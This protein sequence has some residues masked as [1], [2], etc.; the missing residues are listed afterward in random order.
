MRFAYLSIFVCF[1]VVSLAQSITIS[2]K[3]HKTVKIGD[4]TWLGENLAVDQF[5]DGTA[6]RLCK[7]EE[8][9]YDSF[10]KKQPAYMLMKFKE[11][12]AA[13]GYVYNDYAVFNEKS[14]VPE[15]WHIPTLEDWNVL[16]KH[17]AK[18]FDPKTIS[19]DCA[20]LDSFD[21]DDCYKGQKIR[22]TGVWTAKSKMVKSFAGK[23][24][25]GFNA[26]QAIYFSKEEVNCLGGAYRCDGFEGWSEYIGL[27]AW[28][29]S[30]QESWVDSWDNAHTTISIIRLGPA[31]EYDLNYGI[32]EGGFGEGFYIRVIK[33]E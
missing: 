4:Q 5:T 23:N 27:T 32:E 2:G 30:S 18:G 19:E 28:W 22:S 16:D 10:T 24:S 12:N 20:Q 1:S 25:T 8:E 11:S 29:T 33:N 6:L 26:L 13:Y 9:W 21:E 17:L 31:G 7:S 14:L 3:S 15:G